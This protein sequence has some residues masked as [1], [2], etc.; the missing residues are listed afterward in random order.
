MSGNDEHYEELKA[1]TREL[2][3]EKAYTMLSRAATAE[4][5]A[6]KHYLDGALSI[7]KQGQGRAAEAV[8]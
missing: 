6:K 8:P 2:L 1:Q 3:G 4:P 7:Y 5:V